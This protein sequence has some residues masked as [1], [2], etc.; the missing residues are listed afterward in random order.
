MYWVDTV[1]IPV[2]D[3][4]HKIT[5]YVSLRM[6]VTECK[7][8]EE[9]KDKYINV[10]EDIAHVVAHD[11]RGPVCTILGLANIVEKKCGTGCRL[12]AYR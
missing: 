11:L 4:N 6:L 7:R 10:L 9:Q 8:A 1:I 12:S 5:T 3:E 2:F